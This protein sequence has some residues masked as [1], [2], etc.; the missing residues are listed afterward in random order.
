MRPSLVRFTVAATTVIALAILTPLGWALYAIAADRAIDGAR[1]QAAPLIGV[2]ATDPSSDVVADAIKR[3]PDGSA[4]IA[5][6]LPGR[7]PIGDVRAQAAA[8][9]MAVRGTGTRTTSVP[10]GKVLLK[11]VPAAGRTSVIEVFVPDSALRAGVAPR[12]LEFAGLAVVLIAI[13]AMLADRLAL[14][15]ASAARALVNAA[16][17]FGAD[18]TTRVEIGGTSELAD[19]GAAFNTMADRIVRLLRAERELA[20]DLSHRLRTPLTAL[21]LDADAIPAGP[22]AQRIREA[23]DAL[24]AEVDAIIQEQRNPGSTRDDEQNDLVDVLADR[25][26]FWAVLAEDHRRPWQVTGA[27]TPLWVPVPRE[28]LIGA[29]DALLGNVFEHTPQ[30]T[31][32]AVHVQPD[33]F[34][35][36]DAGPGIADV[37][38][39]LRRGE[40]SNGSTGLGLSIVVRVATTVGG[41]I[42]ID[43]GE[44]GGARVA[45]VLPPVPLP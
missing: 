2:V 34:V 29:V 38:S 16:R 26:A 8:A 13:S 4:R 35:V 11:A 45:L 25:L 10:G 39:A 14:R 40:S 33:R 9:A 1:Q 41:T 23:V 17:E 43:R 3:L 21:R 15:H 42:R 24:E 44:L 5:I 37:P 20:A 22:V 12:W 36:E 28:D 18:L 6:Y 30:G 19:A 32:F 7:L 31:A 27:E